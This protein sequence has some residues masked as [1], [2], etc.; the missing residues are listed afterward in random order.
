M[1]AKQIGLLIGSVVVAAL[2]AY[3]IGTVGL[4]GDGP[5]DGGGGNLPEYHIYLQA[6]QFAFNQTSIQVPVDHRIVV[7][8]TTADVAH[9]FGV[10]ELGVDI[11]ASPGQEAVASFDVTSPGT[12]TFR[13]TEPYCGSGH[14]LM[15]GTLIVS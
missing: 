12:Y 10:S 1:Q 6:R 2:V 13:C 9:G 8:L 11:V 5:Q 3:A 7:H 14:P 4:G 15:T